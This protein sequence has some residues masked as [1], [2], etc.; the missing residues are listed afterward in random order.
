M[1]D[2]KLLNEWRSKG[3]KISDFE[4]FTNREKIVIGKLPDEEAKVEYY[5]PYCGFY[6]I[7]VIELERLKSDP[8]KFKRPKFKCSKCGKTIIVEDLKK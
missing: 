1:K 8:T 4:F 7:K 2:S 3:L 5:C 6:E